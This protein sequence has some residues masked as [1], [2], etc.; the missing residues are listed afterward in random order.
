LRRRFPGRA[1]FAT[2]QSGDGVIGSLEGEGE[3]DFNMAFARRFF[4]GFGLGPHSIIISATST[5]VFA[6][7]F[8]GIQN[9]ISSLD[10]QL[11]AT[12]QNY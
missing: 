2:N 3:G 6:V 8:L 4:R 5:I 12:S 11:R 10:N 1:L 7:G 9:F